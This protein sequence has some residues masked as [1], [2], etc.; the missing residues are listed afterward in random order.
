M[1]TPIYVSDELAGLHAALAAAWFTTITL[2]HPLP[3][4]RVDFAFNRRHLQGLRTLAVW[5]VAS[6]IR[7]AKAA[8]NVSYA[9]GLAARVVA[10]KRA[11]ELPSG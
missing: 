10:F 4:D 6:T 3:A 7:A 5:D 1:K 8:G 9:L 11:N 2:A